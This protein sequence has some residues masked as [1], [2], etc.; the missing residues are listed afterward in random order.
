M[1]KVCIFITTFFLTFS[2]L[3]QNKVSIVIKS[4]PGRLLAE[5]SIY[6]SGSFNGWNPSDEQYKF[7][8]DNNGHYLIVLNLPVGKYE[9]KI[10]KG[11]W[12]KVEVSQD[13]K[14][15][16]NRKL[17]V[18]GNMN[19]ELF[20]SGWQDK[21]ISKKATSSASK[22]VRIVETTFFIPQLNRSRRIWVYLPDGYATAKTRYPVLYI[23]DGQNVFE[24]SSSFSGEWGVDEFLDSTGKK[25]CIV[26]AIDNGGDKRLNEYNPFDNAR[27]GKGE[28]DAYLD[29]IVHTLKPY[30]QKKF[31]TIKSFKNTFI[32]GS[33]MGGLISMYAVL[34]YP[35]VFGGAG[36]F[37]P[38]FWITSEIDNYIEQKAKKVKSK[39][40]F[41]AG[42]EEGESMVPGMLKVFEQMARKS[43]ARMT[44]VIRSEGKHNEAT[45]RK[46]FPFFYQWLR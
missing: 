25:K 13:G 17:T 14:N 43:K 24:D 39:I 32:A 41:Y 26:V 38:S 5:E 23:Q 30:I 27:F 12:D 6:I 40:Y 22:N 36:V 8:K 21:F 11:S 10:T 19:L 4:L 44:T 28:G 7:N 34:K 33:S 3:G 15:I 37:S 45:W 35:K 42:M 2:A 31:R 16:E 29:F 9:F 20:I 46:E 18:D 1:K